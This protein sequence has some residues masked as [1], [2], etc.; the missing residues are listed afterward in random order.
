MEWTTICLKIQHL[1]WGMHTT[2][3]HQ[4]HFVPSIRNL[5]PYVWSRQYLSRIM[6]HSLW[7]FLYTTQLFHICIL[8]WTNKLWL[9]LANI[10]FS[11][12]LDDRVNWV[13]RQ[14][15]YLNLIMNCILLILHFRLFL[16]Y[17]PNSKPGN[18]KY[19]LGANYFIVF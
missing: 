15:V 11:L 12:F 13:L 8:S 17:S 9:G 16:K 19:T 2:Q 7:W 5:S 18:M 4:M 1:N 10:R 14:S 6:F 3:N